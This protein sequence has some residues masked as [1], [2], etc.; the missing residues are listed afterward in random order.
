MGNAEVRT[1]QIS[2]SEGS[3]AV[4]IRSEC[5]GFRPNS[6]FNEHQQ[7]RTGREDWEGRIKAL[8]LSFNGGIL[9][10]LIQQAAK[11]LENAEACIDWY[12]REKEQAEEDLAVLR[13]LQSDMQQELNEV[14]SQGEPTE[15]SMESD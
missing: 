3:E 10:R 2:Q 6:Q 13:K 11:H 15:D 9:D 8:I 12:Q 5:S 4:P 7:V 1:S 14:S